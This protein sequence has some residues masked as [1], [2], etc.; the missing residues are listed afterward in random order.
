MKVALSLSPMNATGRTGIDCSGPIR[1]T[2]NHTRIPKTNIL[3]SSRKLKKTNLLQ[4]K[5]PDT[6]NILSTWLFFIPVLLSSNKEHCHIY[7]ISEQKQI[8]IEKRHNLLVFP[9]N[10]AS[11][12]S[13]HKHVCLCSVHQESDIT[14]TRMSKERQKKNNNGHRISCIEIFFYSIQ[15]YRTWGFNKIS[16]LRKY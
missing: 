13:L 5:K 2:E 7:C 14:L 3:S 11:R 1:F 15:Y 4:E 16:L 10:K 12:N 8:R 6:W 9:I